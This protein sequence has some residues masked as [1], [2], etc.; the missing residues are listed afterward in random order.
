MAVGAPQGTPA[1]ED[2]TDCPAPPVNRRDGDKAAEVYPDTITVPEYLLPGLFE[3]IE[4]VR[5]HVHLSVETE[6]KVRGKKEEV[7]RN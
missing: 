4:T 2:G 7:I 3:C 5:N 1:K 6:K